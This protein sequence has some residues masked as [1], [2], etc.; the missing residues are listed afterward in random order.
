MGLRGGKGRRLGQGFNQRDEI[1]ALTGG[2]PGQ[3]IPGATTGEGGVEIDESVLEDAEQIA[4]GQPTLQ[5]MPRRVR[6]CRGRDADALD[7][8]AIQIR[9]VDDDQ[10]AAPEK[11]P[12]EEL[13]RGT[14]PDSRRIELIEVGALAANGSPGRCFRSAGQLPDRV[15]GGAQGVDHLEACA[16]VPIPAANGDEV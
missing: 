6:E 2:G 11:A 7:Q 4:N 12:V 16:V 10:A 3:M 15:A 9:I 8:R 13:F 5:G 1:G 14:D